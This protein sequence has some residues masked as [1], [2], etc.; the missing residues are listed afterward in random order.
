MKP[1][2]YSVAMA[3]SIHQEL[4][5]HLIRS[6]GQEDICFALWHPSRGAT[7]STALIFKVLLPFEGERSVHGNAE[8][9][10]SYLERAL[11]E[12]VSHGSG[13]ALLHS[14]PAGRGWQDLSYVD[15]QSELGMAGSVEAAT[16]HPFVGLTL[17]GVDQSWSSRFW[18]RRGPRDYDPVWCA[19]VRRC[20][21]R[22][23]HRRLRRRNPRIN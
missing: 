6:D 1:N 19:S 12:A 22:L 8:F 5:A 3:E 7:R 23:L 21:E 2:R 15:H 13:L 18:L 17:A 4:A 10:P 20:G 9:L 11:Q 16:G 14:H